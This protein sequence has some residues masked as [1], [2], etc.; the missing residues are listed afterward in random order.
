MIRPGRRGPIPDAAER[1]GRQEFPPAPSSPGLAPWRLARQLPGRPEVPPVISAALN[2]SLQDGA[3]TPK[4]APAQESAKAEI[5]DRPLSDMFVEVL[6]CP[7]LPSAIV[8]VDQA[9]PVGAESVRP[10]AERDPDPPRA[11]EAIAARVS[12]TGVEADTHAPV[13]MEEIEEMG[14]LL[15]VA[16][17]LG[18]APGAVLDQE[19][20]VGRRLPQDSPEA[21]GQRPEAAFLSLSRVMAGVEHDES[22]AEE[23]GSL[24]VIQDRAN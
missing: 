3:E 21:R 24:Q 10:W 19:I 22:A 16:A 23:G 18:A 13:A 20:D 4:L 17:K 14:K 8:E 6:S 11:V 7:G 15:P 1:E 9:D 5:P 2:R 12:M